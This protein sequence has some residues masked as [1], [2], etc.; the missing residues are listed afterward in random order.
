MK[1]SVIITAGGSGN[2]LP[3]KVKKQFLEIKGKPI[4]FHTLERFLKLGNLINEIIISLPMQE[5]DIV[6]DQIK[7][8]YPSFNMKCVSGGRERQN[9]VYNALLSCSKDTDIVFIHD[10]VRPFFSLANI[11]KMLEKVEDKVGVIPVSKVK[12]TV[13]QCSNGKVIRTVPRDELFNV[14]TPQ[15]FSYKTLKNLYERCA[16]SGQLF[17]DDAA[18]Y[19]LF[20]YTVKTVIESD[21]NIKITTQ[22]DLCLAE[23]LLNI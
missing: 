11:A 13:K 4:L 16:E 7:E 22:E 21:L 18:L 14:H 19:E 2:R 1:I 15:C 20:N 23:Y 6:F 17:T 5:K 8:I 9:S 12:F 10:G 3:G